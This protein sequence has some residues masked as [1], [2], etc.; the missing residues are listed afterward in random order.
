VVGVFSPD[1]I[2]YP[3]GYVDQI[4]LPAAFTWLQNFDLEYQTDIRNDRY[5]VEIYVVHVNQGTFSRNKVA[6]LDFQALFQTEYTIEAPNFSA[7]STLLQLNPA[8]FIV[9]GSVK[10]SGIR[11]LIAAYDETKVHGFTI[12]FDVRIHLDRDCS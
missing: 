3:A 4:K 6:C 9:P 5:M 10:F 12:T 1:V 2:D 11:D 8:S 7:T